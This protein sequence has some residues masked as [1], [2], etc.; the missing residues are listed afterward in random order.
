MSS[1]K[2][3]P[4]GALILHHQAGYRKHPTLPVFMRCCA[5]GLGKKVKIL[6]ELSPLEGFPPPGILGS[7]ETQQGRCHR[8]VDRPGTQGR[9]DRTCDQ[10]WKG[11]SCLSPHLARLS[12]RSAPG[13]NTKTPGTRVPGA[14]CIPFGTSYFFAAFFAP[15]KESVMRWSFGSKR[16]MENG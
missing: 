12:R 6:L 2:G 11:P 8:M 16:V 13:L 14:F 3:A 5:L 4:L 15:A 7:I 9:T 10:A 1:K